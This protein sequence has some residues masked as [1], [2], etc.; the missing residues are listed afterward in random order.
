MA[1]H[2]GDEHP[3]ERVQYLAE[4]VREAPSRKAVQAAHER[5]SEPVLAHTRIGTNAAP[6]VDLRGRS[7]M[8]AKSSRHRVPPARD[9]RGRLI[10]V[11][12]LSAAFPSGPAVLS[13][14]FLRVG[15]MGPDHYGICSVGGSL[16]AT[17]AAARA[18]AV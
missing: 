10:E 5:S 17:R 14:L 11:A 2:E 6:H 4:R 3:R 7:L 1:E 16:K 15:D 13:G 8:Q 18:G 9:F 12:L